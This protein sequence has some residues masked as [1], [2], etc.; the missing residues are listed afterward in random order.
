VNNDT[1]HYITAEQSID[2]SARE[3]S[4]VYVYSYSAAFYDHLADAC[5]DDCDPLEDA[6][7][8][9]GWL[10]FWGERPDS[11]GGGEWRVCMRD[12]GADE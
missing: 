8:P 3:S 4:T 12:R 9:G 2:T 10:I 1:Q 6:E 11:E 5:S 7:R